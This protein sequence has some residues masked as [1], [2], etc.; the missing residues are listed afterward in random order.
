MKEAIAKGLEAVMKV[1]EKTSEYLDSA[2]KHTDALKSAY[3]FL[4]Q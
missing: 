1:A 4:K 2:R 3:S